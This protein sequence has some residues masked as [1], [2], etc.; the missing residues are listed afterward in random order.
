MK[1]LLLLSLFLTANL[2]MNAQCSY[3]PADCPESG[4]IE[5]AQD[6]NA[7]INNLIVSQEITMQN[8][9]RSQ[10]I[11]MMD[12]I[13]KNKGWEVYEY[14]ESAGS[15]VGAN[16]VPTPFSLRHP[17]QFTISFDF[18]VNKDSLEAWHNWY[19]NDLQNASNKVVD[20]YK[21]S[22]ANLSQDQGRQKY[23]DSATYYS[24]LKAKYMT[25]HISEYQKA[26]LSGDSKGQKKYEAETKKFDDKIN[27]FINKTTDKT[28]QGFSDSESQ[29]NDLDAYKRKNTI[30]FRNGSVIRASLN[31][32]EYTATADD[33][34]K[35]VVKQ[36]PLTGATLGI[37]IH[38]QSPNEHEI[39]GQYYRSPDVALFL[40]GKWSSSKDQYHDYHSVYSLDKKN[41]DAVT[42]K[43]IPCD[44][45][46][47]IVLHVEGSQK[48][49]NRFLQSFDAQKLD[50]LIVKE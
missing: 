19:Y 23:I 41:T 20:S 24:N 3:F 39:F 31:V 45:V 17:H 10:F 18:V 35:K 37:L 38:N 12:E 7:C 13:A 5:A 1:V 26:L 9:L 40:F 16:G 34:E 25:D 4:D 29:F 50:R 47:T 46:Q 44:K 49:M 32:N 11:S 22:G 42:V 15:G 33:G 2:M 6:S 43:K 28:A 48:Y 21:Q 36:I 14:T 30:A 8:D 27:F